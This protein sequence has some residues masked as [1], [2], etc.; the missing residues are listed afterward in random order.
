MKVILPLAALVAASA[1]LHATTLGLSQITYPVYLPFDAGD[2][3]IEIRALPFATRYAHPE[4]IGSALSAPYVVPNNDKADLPKNIN[5]I[6]ACGVSVKTDHVDIKREAN[7][8]VGVGLTVDITK[9]SK[10]DY[11]PFEDAAIVRAIAKAIR[12]TLESS[13]CQLEN[14]S[15]IS[16]DGQKSLRKLLERRLPKPEFDAKAKPPGVE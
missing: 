5:L 3:E 10:P 1:A 13:Q 11:I 6:N 15:I 4:Y 2:V 9:F 12:K 16:G 8:P 14:V 7:D